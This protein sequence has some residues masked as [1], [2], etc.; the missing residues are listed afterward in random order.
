M[1]FIHRSNKSI[2]ELQADIREFEWLVV[3]NHYWQG[4][5]DDAKAQLERALEDAQEEYDGF[6]YAYDEM[7]DGDSEYR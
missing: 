5:L 6:D 7:K 3:E 2:A 1:K 4:Q